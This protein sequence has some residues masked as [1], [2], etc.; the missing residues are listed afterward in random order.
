MTSERAADDLD[1]FS[2]PIGRGMRRC[3]PTPF[4]PATERA[5]LDRLDEFDAARNRGATEA[6]TAWL[7]R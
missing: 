7:H 6:R 2:F 4:D 5:L 1:E 3:E